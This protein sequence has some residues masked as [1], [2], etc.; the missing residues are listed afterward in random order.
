MLTISVAPVGRSWTYTWLSPFEMPGMK[1]GS[2]VS[3]AT[4]R[5]SSVNW[6]AE[7]SKDVYPVEETLT[8]EVVWATAPWL[9]K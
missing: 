1:L 7:A 9:T 2:R 6:N 5:P 8:F 4:Q 3:K